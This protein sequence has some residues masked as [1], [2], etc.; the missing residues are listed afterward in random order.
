M[1]PF[2]IS[3]CVFTPNIFRY[4]K[5]FSAASLSALFV[6]NAIAAGEYGIADTGRVSYKV[7]NE[8]MPWLAAEVTYA[9]EQ[10]KKFS[11]E[12]RLVNT[13][14]NLENTVHGQGQ[15]MAVM[16]GHGGHG[17]A[18]NYIAPSNPRQFAP[19]IFALSA[20]ENQGILSIKP[21]SI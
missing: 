9:S 7:P 4:L 20:S 15:L 19:R 21:N 1:S 16:D 14:V 17:T 18:A 10:N 3:S 2:L 13:R 6:A 5:S 12:D 11:Q 8:R